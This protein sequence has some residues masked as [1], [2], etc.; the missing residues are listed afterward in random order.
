MDLDSYSRGDMVFSS[1][2]QATLD[3]LKID[4]K[5]MRQSCWK[6]FIA[7]FFFWAIKFFPGQLPHFL[8][9]GKSISQFEHYIP[10]ITF[11]KGL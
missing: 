4:R 2:R 10:V 11:D 5:K 8:V 6:V 9:D 7:Q 1:I 3:Y